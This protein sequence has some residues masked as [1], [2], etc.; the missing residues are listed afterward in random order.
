M[1]PTGGG[2]NRT[3]P[4]LIP[5]GAAV[6]Y[7]VYTLHRRPDL[8]GMDAELFRPERWD[9]DMPMHRSKTDTSW[10]YLPFNGGPRVCLG[11]GYYI[12]L[13][14]SSEETNVSAVDFALTEAAYTVVR[15]FRTF[16]VIRL[17]EGHSVELVGVEKQDTT[18]VVSSTEGCRVELGE[19]SV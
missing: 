6:A 4:V 12:C 11:S 1:L 9:E 10:G 16:P 13:F 17:P 3:A 14:T 15:M 18:L 19:R 2:P 5:K 7:S 8:Y